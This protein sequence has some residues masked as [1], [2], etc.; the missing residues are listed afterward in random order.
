MIRTKG[1]GMPHPQQPSGQGRQPGQYGG[2][3]PQGG[4]PHPGAQGG[5]PHPGAQGGPPHPGAQGGPPHPGPQG[6]PP[7][8]GFQGGPHPGFQAGPHHPAYGG[9]PPR[10]RNTGAI[11]AVAAIVASLVAALGITGFV[12][13][14]FLRSDQANP[15]A[16]DDSTSSKDDPDA[17]IQNLVKA[18]NAKNATGMRSL[19]CADA[20]PNVQT[21]ITDIAKTDGA[22]L[23][24]QTR[25]SGQK[26]RAVLD[27]SVTGTAR[28]FEVTVVRSGDAWCW[29]DIAATNS[30]G[31]S[32][33]GS[34]P[35]PTANP[36]EAKKFVQQV[37][38]K[39]NK[40]DAAGAKSLLC[41]DSRSQGDLDAMIGRKVKL[42]IDPSEQIIT[43]S[44]YVGAD[45]KG[46]ANGPPVSAARM[47]GFRQQN[48]WCVYTIFAF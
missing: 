38:D 1:A 23:A 28:P 6:G 41:P 45:L 43:D 39:V 9:P 22:E 4:P 13:P 24:D 15:A 36:A 8:P 33:K 19:A 37:L 29:H 12:A 11:I 10:R 17:V 5:P 7:P 2:H 26:V 44:G 21:A 16:S 35:Q 42:Q 27:I 34:T 47:S 14:G 46:T 20:G 48:G 18:A 25:V 31:G 40:G 3:P 30:S 32:T